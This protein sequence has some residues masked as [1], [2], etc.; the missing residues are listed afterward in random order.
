MLVEYEKSLVLSTPAPILL[1]RLEESDCGVV[2][3]GASGRIREAF[4]VMAQKKIK[5]LII[6]G[7]YKDSQLKEIF[8]QIVYYPEINPENVVLEKIS[9]STFENALQSRLLVDELHCKNILLMTSQL[10]M[11]RAERVFRAVFPANYQINTYSI[12]NPNKDE[13]LFDIYFETMKSLW[14]SVFHAAPWN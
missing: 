10:H 6:S 9:G 7:V 1:D 11:H 5:R 12:V 2:L 13:S 3:T 4:E 8:P 14:Y